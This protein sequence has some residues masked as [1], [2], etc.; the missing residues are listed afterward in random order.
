MSLPAVSGRTGKSF[1]IKRIVDAV[2]KVYIIG[3]G[4]E[5][6]E[7]NVYGLYLPTGLDNAVTLKCDGVQ[8]RGVAMYG[9]APTTAPPI[10]DLQQ[11]AASSLT[12]GV[13]TI[14][15]GSVVVGSS[16]LAKT[17]TIK[18]TGRPNLGV[19]SAA[20]G[21]GNSGDFP[22]NTA[23]M[24][25]IVAYNATTTFTVTFTPASTGARSTTLTVTSTAGTFTVTLTGTGTSSYDWV[26]WD[27]FAMASIASGAQPGIGGENSV[28]WFNS[29]T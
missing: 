14:S 23:G 21:G 1:T 19:T 10:C 22:V 9:N 28:S 17:F 12:S 2:N 13:S 20:V 25:A 29:A 26:P 5:K 8:W 18:D 7:A 11:P 15:F 16:S 6:V 24:G 3:N 27:I 4:L